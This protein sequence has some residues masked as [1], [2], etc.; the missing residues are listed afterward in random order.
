MDSYATLPRQVRWHLSQRRRPWPPASFLHALRRARRKPDARK[1][2]FLLYGPHMRLYQGG[3]RNGLAP[4]RR[5]I[6]AF[7]LGLRK[8]AVA[9]RLHLSRWTCKWRES[10]WRRRGARASF[11]G[12][13]FRSSD[14][15]NQALIFTST[16]SYCFQFFRKKRGD[17][18]GWRPPWLSLSRSFQPPHACTL[19]STCLYFKASYN[20]DPPDARPTTFTS[21]GFRFVGWMVADVDCCQYIIRFRQIIPTLSVISLYLCLPS[22]FGCTYEY[23]SL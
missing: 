4:R 3:W 8:H 1:H 18:R 12:G 14:C 6:G 19:Q 2:P 17:C 7:V 16:R 20:L 10:R 15:I 5:S 9:S 11:D 21:R 13:V 23:Y 22:Y